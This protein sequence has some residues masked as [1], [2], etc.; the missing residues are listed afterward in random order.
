MRPKLVAALLAV[1]IL[2]L[3]GG[4]VFAATRPTWHPKPGQ[5]TAAKRAA[6]GTRVAATAAAAHPASSSAS[7]V[8]H[9]ATA[10]RATATRTR[11]ASRHGASSTTRAA[12]ALRQGRSRPLV[13]YTVKPGDTL[14]GI[15]KWFKLHGYGSLYAANRV[16]IGLNPNLIRPGERITISRSGLMSLNPATR[17]TGA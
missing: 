4:G 2:L 8:R 7:T 11:A 1:G 15:A 17:S 6:A 9:S 16:T 3:G 5:A 13:T 10:T 12:G 14:S